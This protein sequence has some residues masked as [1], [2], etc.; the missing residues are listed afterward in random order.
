MP[1]TLQQRCDYSYARYKHRGG[2]GLGEPTPTEPATAAIASAAHTSVAQT[3]ADAART[4]HLHCPL[5]PTTLYSV[6]AG[7][8]AI[9]T[10]DARTSAARAASSPAARTSTPAAHSHTHA[11]TSP[12]LPASHL[13]YTPAT[14][15]HIHTIYKRTGHTL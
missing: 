13:L 15:T 9:H 4:C 14:S 10:S 5:T 2:W 8:S 7:T 1:T 3:S 6:R 11:H 12:L